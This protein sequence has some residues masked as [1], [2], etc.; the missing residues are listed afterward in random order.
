MTQ[1]LNGLLVQIAQMGGWGVVLFILLYVVAALTVAPAFPL[2]VAAGA[3][4]GVARGSA[5]VFVGAVLGG[6]AA[7]AVAVRLAGTRW[8]R[9]FDREPRVI[10][11]RNAVKADSVWV[12]F[13]LR[14]SP[15]VPFTMLNY[16]LGLARVRYKDFA[17]ALVGMVPAIVMY[18]YYGKVVGDVTALAAGASPPRGPAYYVFLG[19]GLAA[20]AVATAALTRAARRALRTPGASSL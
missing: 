10:V 4:Y 6:S 7:Y 8:L 17:L 14:L 19:L 16:A 12:Q 2:T 15:I 1:W 20:T 18:T 9:R 3:I 5:V 13:L 11:V